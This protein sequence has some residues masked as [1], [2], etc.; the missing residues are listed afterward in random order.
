MITGFIPMNLYLRQVLTH[1]LAGLALSV[2]IVICTE[3]NAAAVEQAITLGQINGWVGGFSV[4]ETIGWQFHVNTDITVTQLGVWD[5]GG[6][7][8]TYANDIGLWDNSSQLLKSANIPAGTVAT[9]INDFRYVPISPITL[10]P[11]KSYTI[12][13]Y[14]SFSQI[15]PLI[16]QYPQPFTTSS[17]VTWEGLVN[18]YNKHGDTSGLSCPDSGPLPPFSGAFGPNFTYYAAPEPSLLIMMASGLLVV[19]CRALRRRKQ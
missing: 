3:M 5:Q 12:G 8:L 13:V 2:I 11:G 15:N 14:C 4:R 1:R 19:L 18:S 17:G 6:N 7:G 10:T 9:L 16:A